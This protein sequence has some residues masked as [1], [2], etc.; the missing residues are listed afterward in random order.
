MPL[1]TATLFQPQWH[2]LTISYSTNNSIYF[3]SEEK[4]C[5]YIYKN[6]SKCFCRETILLYYSH[7]AFVYFTCRNQDKITKVKMPQH[8]PCSSSLRSWSAV[9]WPGIADFRQDNCTSPKAISSTSLIGTPLEPRRL[10]DD[11]ASSSIDPRNVVSWLR[12]S[13]KKGSS[14][15]IW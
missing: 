10:E 3:I 8:T 4:H 9:F 6:W 14:A 5:I 2:I 13:A 1:M 12:E 15:L 7:E 11:T